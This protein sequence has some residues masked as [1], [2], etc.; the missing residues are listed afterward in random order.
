MVSIIRKTYSGVSS[1]QE[2]EIR[3]RILRLRERIAQAAE[4]GGRKEEDVSLMAVTKT[5]DPERV[6]IALDAGVSLLGENRAQELMEKNSFYTCEKSRIHFIGHLQSNKIRD[7]ISRVSCV[8]SVDSLH[9]ASALSAQAEKA[10]IIMPCLLEVNIGQEES[11]SGFSPEGVLDAAGEIAALPNL[12]LRGLMTVAPASA[13]QNH[14]DRC[15]GRMQ[16][17]FLA[18]R[19]KEGSGIDT[20]SM[21][22][23]GDFEMAVRRG[24][25]LVRIGQGIFGARNYRTGG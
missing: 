3:E 20:L 25:T 16:E 10:G 12:S 5:V 8:E 13:G 17:L 11:K 19:E 1:E 18:L 15:F 4:E 23:T 2:K 7:I 9:L 6:N 24:S 14:D 21:G 22:M